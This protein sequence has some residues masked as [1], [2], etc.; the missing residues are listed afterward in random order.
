MPVITEQELKAQMNGGALASLYLLKGQEKLLVKRAANKLIRQAGGEAFPEFNRSELSGEAE[1]EQIADAAAALPF[2]AGHKC[3]AVSDF[4]AGERPQADLEKLLELLDDLPETTTLVLYFPT[5]AV[6]GKSAKWKRLVERAGKRG[7]VVDFPQREAGDLRQILNKTAERQGCRLTR[8]ALN[9]LLEY[10][11]S[12]LHL[13]LCE[14]EKLCAYTLGRGEQEIGPEAVELLTAKSTEATVFVMMDALIAGEARRVY[15]ILDGL[16]FQN[17]EPVMI[18]G[19]MVTPYLD[20]LRVKA[21][22]DSGLPTDAP[23]EYAP[24]YKPDRNKRINFRLRKAQQNLRLFNTQT[25]RACLNLLLEADGALKGSQLDG[26]V[27]MER[28][29]AQLMAAQRGAG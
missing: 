2:M 20:M 4:N 1:V 5:L 21:A 17:A 22:M 16:F 9:R 25:L 6:D 23:L 12:D 13:L 26:R 27:V 7:Y 29:A 18:L 11:G 14:M 10:A 15:A 24:E 3:V 8:P 19:A 28:L